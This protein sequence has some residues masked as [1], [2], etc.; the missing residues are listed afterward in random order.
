MSTLP[1]N[2]MSRGLGGFSPTPT[3]SHS[4]CHLESKPQGILRSKLCPPAPEG[5]PHRLQCLGHQVFFFL[6]LRA[7]IF[8]SAFEVWGVSQPS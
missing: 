6:G 8:L 4:S 1:H 7:S 2:S 5:V 3:A